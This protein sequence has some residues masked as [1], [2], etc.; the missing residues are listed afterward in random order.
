[1]EHRKGSVLMSA[2]EESQRD[3]IEGQYA[4]FLIDMSVYVTSEQREKLMPV[5][6]L[7]PAE[8]EQVRASMGNPA[9]KL[10]EISRRR[11]WMHP[12]GL[13]TLYKV[14]KDVSELDATVREYVKDVNQYIGSEIIRLEEE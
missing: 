1:M 12:L 3:W 4:M 13:G 14:I 6:R 7:T 2:L 5:M 10:F 9:L 8:K 11:G